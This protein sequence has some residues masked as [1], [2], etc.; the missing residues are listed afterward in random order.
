MSFVPDLELFIEPGRSMVGN[1]ATRQ[2]GDSS[3]QEGREDWVYIDAG[4]F[5]RSN[6]DNRR[7][8]V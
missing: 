6:R 4:V 8:Q 2:S 3:Q 1:S 5:S 7:F